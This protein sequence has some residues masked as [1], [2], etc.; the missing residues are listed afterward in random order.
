MILNGAFSDVTD[1]ATFF[2]DPKRAQVGQRNLKD[3]KNR[4]AHIL[5]KLVIYALT[6]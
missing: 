3:K 1:G 6:H 4:Q 2:H 5:Q